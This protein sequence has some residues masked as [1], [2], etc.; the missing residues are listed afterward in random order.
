[1]ATNLGKAAASWQEPGAQEQGEMP[2]VSLG[3]LGILALAQPWNRLLS[4]FYR[5]SSLNLHNWILC[6]QLMEL[7][8]RDS[9]VWPCCRSCV[10][11]G[12]FWGFK[13]PHHCLLLLWEGDV[14]SQ[15]L[16]QS[17]GFLVGC[18]EFW[19]QANVHPWFFILYDGQLVPY[20]LPWESWTL[21]LWN[22]MLQIKCSLYKLHWA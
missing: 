19:I 6:L 14:S 7:F 5:S 8:R 1:M 22:C 17:H 18:G 9:Q 13:C 4:L 16:P 3:S 20:F 11:G 2:S 12:M 15:P 10:T 21:T